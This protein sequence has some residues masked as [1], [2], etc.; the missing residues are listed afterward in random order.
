MMNYLFWDEILTRHLKSVQFSKIQIY[1]QQSSCDGDEFKPTLFLVNAPNG[2]D[3][4]PINWSQEQKQT[5][6]WSSDV[7]KLFRKQLLDQ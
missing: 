3:W 6:Y 5:P 1:S 7:T 2:L 4:P